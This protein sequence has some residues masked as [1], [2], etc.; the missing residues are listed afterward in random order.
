MSISSILT[1]NPSGKAQ[2]KALD[3]YNID[4]VLL[5]AEFINGS[6][7]TTGGTGS[8]GETGSTG[9]TG[10]TGSVGFGETGSTGSSGS[11]GATGSTGAIGSTGA[12]ASLPI[13]TNGQLAIGRTSQL[14]NP[15]ADNIIG[16]TGIS[17]TNGV[18]AISVASTLGESKSFTPQMFFNGT[19]VD[20]V[21]SSQN[22][23]YAIIGK[24]MYISAFLEVSS[25]PFSGGVMSVTTP[26]LVKPVTY[27]EGTVGGCTNLFTDDMITLGIIANDYNL[28]LYSPQFNNLYDYAVIVPFSL[29]YSAIIQIA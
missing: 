1:G 28:Y 7:G 27:G 25:I 19:D 4:C 17:I 21:Y 9:S 10:A 2:W 14:T 26:N 13:L 6:T 3:V 20:V 5:N 18:G 12:S 24:Y 15:V 16:S 23:L 22:G 29:Y 11:T 8:A